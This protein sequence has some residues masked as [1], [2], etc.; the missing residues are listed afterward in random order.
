MPPA[1]RWLIP[2]ELQ[3]DMPLLFRRPYLNSPL[4]WRLQRASPRKMATGW[5]DLLAKSSIQAYGQH[6][7]DARD[8]TPAIICYLATGMIEIPATS[9]NMITRDISLL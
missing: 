2:P 8:T 3:H 9:E 6:F 7:T 4:R 1:R 5:L